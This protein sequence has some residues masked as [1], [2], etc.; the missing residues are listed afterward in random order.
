MGLRRRDSNLKSSEEVLNMKGF[1]SGYLLPAL[2]CLAGCFATANPASAVDEPAASPTEIC[3]ILA[4][5]GIPDVVL[6]TVEG[7]PFSLRNEVKGTA[8][9]LIFY[10]GGW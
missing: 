10:R 8:T 7:E 5:T 2:L 4:G 6:K 9:V 3:P 1:F